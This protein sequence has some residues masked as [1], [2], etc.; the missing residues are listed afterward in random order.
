MKTIYIDTDYK[1][2]IT[3]DGTMNAVET[4]FFDGYCDEYIEGY[5]HVPDGETWTRDDGEEFT[6]E[7][8]TPWTDWATLDAAQREYERAQYAAL[9]AQNADMAAALEVL[10]VNE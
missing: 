8:I 2:H 5:R 7:M 10:G 6:G 1:C 9:K 4:T 3:D